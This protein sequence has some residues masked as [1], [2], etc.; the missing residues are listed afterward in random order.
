MG[1]CM[2]K[3]VTAICDASEYPLGIIMVGVGDGPW[4]MMRDFDDKLKQRK[5][6]NFQFV[7]FT[8]LAENA[9]KNGWTREKWEADFAMKALTEVPEQFASILRHGMLGVCPDNEVPEVKVLEPP[10]NTGAIA[11]MPPYASGTA[12]V[13]AP[14]Y[15]V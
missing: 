14:E 8:R 12:T 9:A 1:S 4:D 11:F 13:K 7:N 5:F 3:T 15:A 10:V 6:D 2:N